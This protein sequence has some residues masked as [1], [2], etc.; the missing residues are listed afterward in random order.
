M[1]RNADA[2]K[3][4]L[5]GTQSYDA[6]VAEK[7]AVDRAVKDF[8]GKLRGGTGDAQNVRHLDA[9]SGANR[10]REIPLADAVSPVPYGAPRGSDP[11][12]VAQRNRNVGPGTPGS[13]DLKAMGAGNTPGGAEEMEELLDGTTTKA[14]RVQAC[15]VAIRSKCAQNCQTSGGLNKSGRTNCPYCLGE[16]YIAKTQRESR[17]RSSNHARHEMPTESFGPNGMSGNGG[18]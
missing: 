5:E 2:S 10:A 3:Q 8:V 17:G 11:M 18:Q 1:N 7:G 9:A 12:K 14:Q 13:R 6:K 4:F 16:G 15:L